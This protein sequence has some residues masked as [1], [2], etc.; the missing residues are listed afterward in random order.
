MDSARLL[1]ESLREA[2]DLKALEGTPE[3]LHLEV[4]AGDHPLSQE[5]KGYISQA[6][7]GFAN[8][9]GGVL[10]MGLE[11]RKASPEAPDTIV[12][13]KPFSGFK[14]VGSDV[15]SLAGKAV[16]PVVD[17]VLVKAIES[18]K[19][20]DYG[21]VAMLVPV[22]DGGPHRAMLKPIGDREYWKR[23]GESFYRMEHYDIADMFGRRRRPKLSLCWKIVPG[24]TMRVGGAVHY[25]YNLCFGLKNSGKGIARYPMLEFEFLIFLM[26]G[27]AG[28]PAERRFE[29]DVTRVVHPRVLFLP[30]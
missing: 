7:S 18:D 27:G 20:A 16:V 9:D 4:K 2:A 12:R 30:I 19:S 29:G 17:G 11:A 10:L 13:V 28:T 21:Y 1:Y 23:S 6:L 24:P 8:S 25:E 5:L 26:P 14:A 3:H 15:L 22:S